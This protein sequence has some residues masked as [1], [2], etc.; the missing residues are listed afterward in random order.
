MIDLTFCNPSTVDKSY[1]E[2]NCETENQVDLEMHTEKTHENTQTGPSEVE[3]VE[4]KQTEI[5]QSEEEVYKCSMCEFET[6]HNPGL[7]SHMS[8]MHG[9]KTKHLCDQCSETFETRKKLKNHIYC[10]H[11]GKYKTLA[12]LIDEANP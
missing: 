3:K 5:G 8:K 2:C 6:T 12:Q 9:H 11:S 7:K 4:K 10:I 1:Q